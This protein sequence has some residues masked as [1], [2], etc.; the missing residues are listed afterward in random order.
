M[1]DSQPASNLVAEGKS[2][3]LTHSAMVVENGSN[4]VSEV[5]TSGYGCQATLF[6]LVESFFFFFFSYYTIV[7]SS[8]FD[9]TATTKNSQ[10][11]CCQLLSEISD[12]IRELFSPKV[13]RKKKAPPS[14]H[15]NLNTYSWYLVDR[16]HW[17]LETRKSCIGYLWFSQRLPFRR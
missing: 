16:D 12:K 1:I 17:H 5:N 2:T 14:I 8:C 10:E 11:V 9:M 6:V 15:R 4:K 7:S 3:T 13:L